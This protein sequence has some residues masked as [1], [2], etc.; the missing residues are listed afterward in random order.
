MT[1]W[2]DLLLKFLARI[3]LI[4][5]YHGKDVAPDGWETLAIAWRWRRGK[6]LHY[7][8]VSRGRYIPRPPAVATVAEVRVLV[9]VNCDGC[10]Y[11]VPEDVEDTCHA[12][13]YGAPPSDAECAADYWE[14]RREMDEEAAVL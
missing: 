13:K 2:R 14:A 7:I 12:P 9:G 3:G 8:S 4:R 5:M 11:D 6:V 10:P 1:E